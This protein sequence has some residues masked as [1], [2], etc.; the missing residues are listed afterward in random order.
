MKSSAIADRTRAKENAPRGL[1]FNVQANKAKE[2]KA[3]DPKLY[4]KLN[5]DS[6]KKWYTKQREWPAMCTVKPCNNITASETNEVEA[7][8][9]AHVFLEGDPYSVYIL[10]TCR[11]CNTKVIELEYIG[12][13]LLY[14]VLTDKEL[15]TLS[16]AHA[17]SLQS[18]ASKEKPRRS[19]RIA[20]KM[21]AA[22]KKIKAAAT[23]KKKA[24]RA[25]KEELVLVASTAD[26]EDP[27]RDEV[28]DEVDY[29][30]TSR[31]KQRCGA[32]TKKKGNPPCQ[33]YKGTCPHH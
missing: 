24:G 10:P 15:K 7:E 9:G 25:A 18:G 8:H 22:A 14:C 31:G 17:R 32:P 1:A 3:A 21:K 28:R 5:P 12:F 6:A 19:A 11:T 2:L 29:E 27:V 13:P 33:N 30:S 16:E 23:G 4:K 20:A 26:V